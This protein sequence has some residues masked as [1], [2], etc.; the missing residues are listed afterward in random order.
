MIEITT[1]TKFEAEV[2]SHDGIVLVDFW[3]PWCGP[4][5]MMSSVLE[6]VNGSIEGLKIVKIDVDEAMELA[7]E[8]GIQSVPTLMLFKNGNMV[9][10]RSGFMSKTALSEWIK[11]NS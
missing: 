7:S 5:R 11:E 4:C 1:K 3:A 8:H 10:S 6:D 9:D 2:L